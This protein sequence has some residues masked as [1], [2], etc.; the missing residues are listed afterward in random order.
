MAERE[1]EKW[2]TWKGKH[3]PIYKDSVKLNPT[4]V[5]GGK[6]P[7]GEWTD[8]YE[9]IPEAN[10]PKKYSDII[11][12]GTPEALDEAKAEFKRETKVDFNVYSIN[13]ENM[14]MIM[15]AVATVKA[16]YNC[17]ITDIE[18]ATSD[19]LSE[20]PDACAWMGQDG[21]MYINAEYFNRS[22]KELEGDWR[23]SQLVH[24]NFHPQGGAESIIVHEMG[25]AIF[26]RF[27]AN[28]IT[29]S[30]ENI[31]SDISL[32]ESHYDAC[33]RFLIT[34]DKSEGFSADVYRS[35]TGY[36]RIV[37]YFDELG[38]ELRDQPYLK[39]KW[40]GKPTLSLLALANTK[41]GYNDA[42]CEY[43]GTNY[44][45]MVAEA[46]T[47]VFMNGGS[48]SFTSKFIYDRIIAKELKK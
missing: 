37:D 4:K 12:E 26:N 40:G 21:V 30:G 43:A 24:R 7:N 17:N 34:K 15:D 5:F 48:A 38:N 36:K 46:F 41:Y 6:L 10:I 2:I 22:R 45:E 18:N 14:G 16:K 20:S 47:D 31:M 28:E 42:I 13:G 9:D 25:H 23:G 8:P 33:Q 27:V 1:I 11:A 3:I 35:S 39:E 32:W 29:E 44:H 19:M